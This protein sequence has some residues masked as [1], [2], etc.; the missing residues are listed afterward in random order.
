[1]LGEQIS[2]RYLQGSKRKGFW[3]RKCQ[4]Q[5]I[6]SVSQ[7]VM[8]NFRVSNALRH[9]EGQQKQTNKQKNQNWF[10]FGWTINR[11]IC[12]V[13]LNQSQLD[14]NPRGMDRKEEQ[15]LEGAWQRVVGVCKGTE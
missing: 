10:K 14:P 9:L 12:A 4:R 1:M 2:R 7:K 5:R 8:R 15:V 3:V 13:S 11:C 6:K